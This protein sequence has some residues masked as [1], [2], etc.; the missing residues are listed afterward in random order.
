MH[1]RNCFVTLTYA[2][3]HLARGGTLVKG[4]LSDF[5]RRVRETFRP[6]LVRFYGIGE[7]GTKTQRPHYHALLF[8]ADFPRGAVVAKGEHGC[9]VY[10]STALQSHWK[11]GLVSIGDLT[12]ESAAYCARYALKKQGAMVHKRLSSWTDPDTGEVIY[13]TPEFALMSRRPGIGKTWLT[14]YKSDVFP[15]D[16]IIIKE[17]KTRVPRYYVKQLS[18]TEAASVK[19]RRKEFAMS[20]PDNSPG[21]LDARKAVLQAKLLFKLTKRG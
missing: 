9:A 21:R 11:Y 4:H 3:C 8:G 17:R 7:Y 20:S 6:E 2:D 12:P 14:A 19:E 1:L 13:R 16:F 10:A 5:V 15:D 18:E